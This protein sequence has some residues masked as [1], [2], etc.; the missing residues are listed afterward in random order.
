MCVGWQEE[1]NYTKVKGI[2]FCKG[3]FN[4]CDDEAIS[5]SFWHFLD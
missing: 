1:E 3:I 5:Y 4:N 2:A